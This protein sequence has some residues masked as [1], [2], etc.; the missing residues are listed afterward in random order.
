MRT[1]SKKMLS[2]I[3]AAITVDDAMR[4]KVVIDIATISARAVPAKLSTRSR[5]PL[6]LTR[7]ALI[8]IMLDVAPRRRTSRLVSAHMNAEPSAYAAPTPGEVSASDTSMEVR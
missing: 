8:V 5:S 3:P 4:T 7:T 2:P 1:H 6:A